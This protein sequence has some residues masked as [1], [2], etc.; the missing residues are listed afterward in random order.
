M[1]CLVTT[2]KTP[3]QRKASHAHIT[4]HPYKTQ[5]RICQFPKSRR[6]RSLV[7]LHTHCDH[8]SIYV[9]QDI[10]SAS[11]PQQPFRVY[12]HSEKA[13]LYIHGIAQDPMAKA[14]AMHVEDDSRTFDKGPIAG[15]D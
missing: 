14:L 13:L 5:K 2:T 10:Q 12:R 6:T 3:Q 8:H 11:M 1:V 7:C 15:G 4:R 9:V